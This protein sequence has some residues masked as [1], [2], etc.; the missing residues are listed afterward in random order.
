MMSSSVRLLTSMWYP[1][2]TCS[3]DAV[4]KDAFESSHENVFLQ[5]E[6]NCAGGPDVNVQAA[7]DF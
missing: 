5:D 4:M 3:G 6:N 7:A 2:G 1:T